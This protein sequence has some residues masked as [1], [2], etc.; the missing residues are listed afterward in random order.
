MF[1]R[2]LEMNS[3]FVLK[4]NGQR[5]RLVGHTLFKNRWLYQ[6]LREEDGKLTT[7]HHSC[8]VKPIIKATATS[9]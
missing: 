9:I 7:L 2:E 6:C 4:R 3:R 1:L 8:H 5:Y